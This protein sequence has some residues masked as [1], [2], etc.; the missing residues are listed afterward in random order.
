MKQRFIHTVLTVIAMVLCAAA[1]IFIP[2]FWQGV[3]GRDFRP[4]A[5]TM[6]VLI[7]ILG[8]VFR[9]AL[10][11]H[12]LDFV[13]GLVAA[14]FLTLCVIAHFSGFT[15]VELFHWFN[16][17]WLAFMSLFVGL[18]WLVGLGVGSIWLKFSER[19]EQDA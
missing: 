10:R 19:H 14:E 8:V 18:P 5:A 7:L 17:S 15:G 2:P 9:R 16:L 11:W 6:A 12:V 1:G 4:Q 3:S 13:F